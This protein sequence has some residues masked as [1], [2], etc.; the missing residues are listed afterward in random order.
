MS[1][2]L[3]FLQVD[4]VF[5]PVRKVSYKVEDSRQNNEVTGRINFRNLD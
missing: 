2:L 1:L 4:A 3:D 5:M